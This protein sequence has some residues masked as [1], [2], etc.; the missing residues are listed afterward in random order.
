MDVARDPVAPPAPDKRRSGKSTERARASLGRSDW[1][2]AALAAIAQGGLGAVSV[3]RLAKQLGAT[4]GSFYWHFEDRSDLIRSALAEWESRDT[5]A[6]IEHASRVED[7][8]ERL[9]SLFRL[10]FDESARVQIDLSLLADADDPDVAAALERVAAKRLRY[11][12]EL[13]Q[14]MGSKAGSDRALLAYTAFIGLAH[15]RRTADE[16]TPRGRSSSRYI[17][18]ITTWLIE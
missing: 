2:D 18:N 5:D 10:V 1:V 3:E 15:L 6:V 16:L 9:Q 12:D 8:R 14:A 13:F 11:I 17:T 7:P 4:K